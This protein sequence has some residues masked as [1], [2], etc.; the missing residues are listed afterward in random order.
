MAGKNL[1]RIAYMDDRSQRQLN[2]LTRILA[3]ADTLHVA[4]GVDVG[5]N[6]TSG[7]DFFCRAGRDHWLSRPG[8]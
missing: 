7:R 1:T 4:A 2:D 3:A 8:T 5:Q 6:Q